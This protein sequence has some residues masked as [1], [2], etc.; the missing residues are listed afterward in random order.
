MCHHAIVIGRA[1]FIKFADAVRHGIGIYMRALVCTVWIVLQSP[2]L[3]FVGN[4]LELITI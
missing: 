2:P 4:L 1:R 3:V